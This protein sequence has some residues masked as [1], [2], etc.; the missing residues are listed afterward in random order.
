M[1]GG[2][3]WSQN[4]FCWKSPQDLFKRLHVENERKIKIKEDYTAFNKSS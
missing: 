1:E 2:H 4:I 3:K